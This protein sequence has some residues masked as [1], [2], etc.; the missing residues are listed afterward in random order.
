MTIKLVKRTERGWIGHYC[1]AQDC[2]FRRNTLLECDGQA[3]VIS[4]VGLKRVGDSTAPREIGFERWY[5]TMAFMADMRDA[6]KDADVYRQVFFESPCAIE[7]EVF[8]RAYDI[9][10][11]A[12]DMHEAVVAEITEKL[13]FGKDLEVDERVET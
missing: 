12:N 1:D 2:L 10:L 7:G 4:S 11:Q 3:V 8:P 9:D 6:Y 13:R 5:E